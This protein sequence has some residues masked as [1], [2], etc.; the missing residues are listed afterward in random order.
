LSAS[1]TLGRI[2]KIGKK[3]FSR[4]VN[5]LT[6]MPMRE[7]VE[8]VVITKSATTAE[9]L[10]KAVILSKDPDTL[11][12][13]EPFEYLKRIDGHRGTTSNGFGKWVVRDP[14]PLPRG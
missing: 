1:S 2:V 6:A 7:T 8:A 14:S 3:T 4:I 12:I 11:P 10:S 9:A 13:H 5:P